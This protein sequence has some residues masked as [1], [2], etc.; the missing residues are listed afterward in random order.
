LVIGIFEKGKEFKLKENKTCTKCDKGSIIGPL[1]IRSSII[2]KRRTRFCRSAA[3]DAYTCTS[4]G[5]TEIYC[6]KKG[7]ENI[8]MYGPLSIKTT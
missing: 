2:L 8:D 5:F 6:D 4:C 3:M 7:L 1:P